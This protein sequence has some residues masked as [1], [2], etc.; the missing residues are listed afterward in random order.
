LVLY[1]TDAAGDRSRAGDLV[2]NRAG[3]ELAVTYTLL[4][5]L[6]VSLAVPMV[7]YQDRASTLPGVTD[8]LQSIR[9][10]AFGDLRVTPKF[11]L[12]R[13]ASGAPIDV[14]VQLGVTVPTG[15]SK[16]YR[17]EASLSVVPELLFSRHDGGWRYALN[18]GYLARKNAVVADQQI[19]DEIAVR[20]GIGYRF[21]SKPLELDVTISSAV[22]A[23]K[24]FERFNQNHL[25]AIA[26]PAY[27][28]GKTILFAAGGVGLAPAFG[29][30]DWRLIVGA[31]IGRLDDETKV[32]MVVDQ[33]RDHDGILNGD[34]KCPD[35]AEDKDDF[36]DQDGCIDPDNDN[37]KILDVNDKCPLQP[38]TVNGFEDA[39]GCPD[40]ADT[41]HDGI[42]DD[43]DKCPT[44]AEDK[45]A[46]QDDDGCPDPDND[47]DLVLDGVDKCPNVA[48]PAENA[49]CPDVDSD[50]DGVVDRLD[51]CP[52]EAGTAKN[53]GCKDKQRVVL[54]DGKLDILDAVYFKLNKADIL[55]KSNSLLD[56]VA[57]VINA[58]T[59]IPKVEIQGHTDSQGN[60]AYN[61]DLSDRR[62]KE[63]RQYLIRKG[64][65]AD[66]LD[67]KG[68]GETQPIADNKTAKGRS[69]NRRVVFKLMGPV[70]GTIDQQN[71]GP[72]NDTLEP[73]KK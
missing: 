35:V 15:A 4:R 19:Q 8:S 48:G 13:Q 58:H 23:A 21:A 60:D 68:Y 25:E 51:N 14:A 24:P 62:A 66:R 2:R 5:H 9:G 42:T 17:G 38:E 70:D 10:V 41:D 3:A 29:T 46:F 12:L 7:L 54:R 11:G 32:A 64:V 49:G 20:A 28:V 27:R 52:T 73:G 56:N 30:P 67:A 40:Q 16:N 44:E 50:K 18:L 47:A 61:L 53:Q 1:Q 65:A 39:D 34:D 59:E 57:N 55:S 72:S 63:V 69:A 26:G 45:D 6:Q 71:S 43:K 33:D 36:E 22:A 37:D 31:R